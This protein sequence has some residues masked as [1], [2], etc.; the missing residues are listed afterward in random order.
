MCWQSRIWRRSTAGRGRCAGGARQ[1]RGA[2]RDRADRAAVPVPQPGAARRARPLPERQGARVV[3]RRAAEHGPVVLHLPS[4][5]LDHRRGLPVPLRGARGVGQSGD[6]LVEDP[7][8]GA[9]RPDVPTL[10]NVNLKRWNWSLK[11]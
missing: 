7:R 2:R 5:L 4:D 1:A 6:G 11:C 8:A 3:A 9:G 10:K